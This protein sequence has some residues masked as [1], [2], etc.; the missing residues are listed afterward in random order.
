MDSPR[1][2]NRRAQLQKLIDEAGHAADL[3]RVTGTP[4]THISA[5]LAGRRGI[6]DQLAA[7]MESIMGKHVGWMDLPAAPVPYP[8]KTNQATAVRASE[9]GPAATA[10]LARAVETL[11]L[12]ISQRGKLDRRQLAVLLP[13]LAEEPEAQQETCK[14]IMRLLQPPAGYSEP[15]TPG[16]R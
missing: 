1:Q 13:L 10:E 14:A 5:I 3:S 16:R 11:A 2:R 12:A 8:P 4:K 9:P 6:G 7:K 15:P